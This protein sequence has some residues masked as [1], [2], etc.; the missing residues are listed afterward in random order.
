[1]TKLTLHDAKA[2]RGPAVA[3]LVIGALL[4]GGTIPAAAD[5]GGEPGVPSRVLDVTGTAW[6]GTFESSI[7]VDSASDSH[8]WAVER[9]LAGAAPSDLVYVTT[10]CQRVTFEPGQRYL[11]STGNVRSPTGSD[12]VAYRLLGHGRVRVAGFGFPAS[13]YQPR[14]RVTSLPDALALLGLGT[15]PETDTLARTERSEETPSARA[16]SRPSS[17]SEWC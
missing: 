3:M 13:F 15:L 11:V 7:P 9:S 1:M 12:T 8:T 5:C 6:I 17:P 14:W 2:F 4:L 16:S 10:G